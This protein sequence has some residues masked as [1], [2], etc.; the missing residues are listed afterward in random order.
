MCVHLHFASCYRERD[1]VASL[2]VSN[3]LLSA[4]SLGGG[5]WLS[6]QTV[7]RR[8]QFPVRLHLDLSWLK[9]LR[10]MDIGAGEVAWC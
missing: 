1:L 8:P 4:F 6:E 10:I 9:A 5:A 3:F 7:I 2:A